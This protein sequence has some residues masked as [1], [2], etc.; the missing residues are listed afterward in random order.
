MECL[1]VGTEQPDQ[2]GRIP[3]HV[4]TRWIEQHPPYGYA[5]GDGLVTTW[6]SPG[7]HR[8]EVRAIE[9]SG[10]RSTDIVKGCVLPAPAPP[11]ALTGSWR[12]DV[13]TSS[14][15]NLPGIY[16]PSGTYRLTFDKRWMSALFPGRF[17]AG[18]GPNAS[19]HNGH[20]WIIDA[21]GT[22]AASTITVAGAVNH[23]LYSTHINKA[24][25]GAGHTNPPSTAGVSTPPPSP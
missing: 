17:V 21:F 16:N 10:A 20:G 3:D 14:L 15:N 9:K 19:T 18:T 7:T 23:D 12:R 13:D 22:Y 24:D 11:A 2:R 5:D 6:L 8:F 1:P 4:T 25:S